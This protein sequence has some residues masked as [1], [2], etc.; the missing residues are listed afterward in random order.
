[1]AT[2]IHKYNNFK[3]SPAESIPDYDFVDRTGYISHEMQLERLSSAGATLKRINTEQY[4]YVFDEVSKAL[5]DD[6]I[7]ELVSST[8]MQ[9]A[10]YDKRDIDELYKAKIEKYQKAKKDSEL[11]SS[12]YKQYTEFVSKRAQEEKTTQMYNDIYSVIRQLKSEGKI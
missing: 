8:L 9:N 7:R 6:N 3:R 11:L 5:S 1:M 12:Y 10:H 4:S 2:I